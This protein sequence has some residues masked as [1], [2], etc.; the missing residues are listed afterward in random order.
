MS[1][2]DDLPR[3]PHPDPEVEAL[4]HFAPVVRK[5]VRHDGWLAERQREFIIALTVIGHAEQAAI[6]VGG[7]M[8]GAYKLRSAD[9]GEGFARSWDSALALHLRRNPRPAP[10]G[11]P[12]RGEIESGTGRKPWP[13][14]GAPAPPEPVDPEQEARDADLFWKQMLKL[15][16]GKLVAERQARLEGRIV[17]ADH[18]VW[19]LSWLEVVFD[20]GGHAAKLLEALRCGDRSLWDV[21]ATPVSEMLGRVRREIWLEKGEADRP[22]PPPPG[23]RDSFCMIRPRHEH[24]PERDGDYREW[25]RRQQENESLA[26]EAQREWEE[27][28]RVEAEAWAER[29]AGKG[30]GDGDGG[31]GEG[32]P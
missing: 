9:G 26:A 18:Y 8:S 30:G 22:P 27:K 21:T 7:T 10:K 24:S 5:C 19:Q 3:K 28:A 25:L 29:E 32:P 23:P 2:Q 11:R 12:S 6:A 4:L 13:A 1:D 16:R 31:E 17:E 14:A 20:L 15:Y